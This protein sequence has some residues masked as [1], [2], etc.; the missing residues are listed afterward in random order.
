MIVAKCDELLN[1][2]ITFQYYMPNCFI[3]LVDEALFL[4]IACCFDLSNIKLQV[5]QNTYHLH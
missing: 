5:S 3:Y 2:I 4:N 1:N